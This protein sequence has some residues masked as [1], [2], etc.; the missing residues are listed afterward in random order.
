MARELQTTRDARITLSN[1]DG[2][3]SLIAVLLAAVHIE[4]YS[5][6]GVGVEG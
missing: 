2:E 4:G 6:V 3:Q 5:G 1:T